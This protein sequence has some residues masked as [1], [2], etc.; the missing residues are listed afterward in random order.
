VINLILSPP[1]FVWPAGEQQHVDEAMVGA[2]LAIVSRFVVARDSFQVRTRSREQTLLDSNINAT[3][4]V[5]SFPE[6][7]REPDHIDKN[8]FKSIPGVNTSPQ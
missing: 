8:R 6:R 4:G 5:V 1:C 2:E 3:L 7:Y